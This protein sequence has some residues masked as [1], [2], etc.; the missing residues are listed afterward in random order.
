MKKEVKMRK[1]EL[2]VVVFCVGKA[3]KIKELDFSLCDFLRAICNFTMSLFS[4]TNLVV[5]FFTFIK[6]H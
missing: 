4:N 3:E 1:K 2:I 6:T 5:C